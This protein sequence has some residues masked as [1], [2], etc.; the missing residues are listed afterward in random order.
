MNVA[1][2][3]GIIYRYDGFRWTP[4][5]VDG[6]RQSIQAID[7]DGKNGLAAGNGGKV[8]ERLS[9]G[10]WRRYTTSTK[11]KFRG[12]SRGKNGVDVAAGNG[13]TIVERRG[14]GGNSSGNQTTGMNNTADSAIG[15]SS[16]PASSAVELTDLSNSP[17]V[18]RTYCEGRWV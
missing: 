16:S 11:T 17:K 3:N 4:H 6:G 14:D 9:A 7:R 5:V 10:Q 1:G 8:Y 12:V 15:N 2:G 13:G 18:V